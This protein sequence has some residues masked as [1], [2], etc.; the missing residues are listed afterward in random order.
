MLRNSTDSAMKLRI[1]NVV[2]GEKVDLVNVE[3]AE[4]RSTCNDNAHAGG[5]SSGGSFRSISLTG[6]GTLMSRIS[7]L[8][9]L[10][11]S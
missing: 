4:V 10:S 3:R 2:D 9:V 11:A 7:A 6:L 8:E 1:V 5:W